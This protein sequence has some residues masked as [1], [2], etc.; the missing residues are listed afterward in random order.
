MT[1][2]QE[3]QRGSRAEDLEAPIHRSNKYMLVSN[4]LDCDKRSV[5]MCVSHSLL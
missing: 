3:L 4:F 2:K 5:L 1:S